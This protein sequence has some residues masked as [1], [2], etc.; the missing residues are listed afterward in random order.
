MG[1]H[2][3]FCMNMGWRSKG[4]S[5]LDE[6]IYGHR[7]LAEKRA[8]N[9]V[10]PS[11]DGAGPER[12]VVKE[13]ALLLRYDSPR[14]RKPRAIAAANLEFSAS[15]DGLPLYWL[16]PSE[17]GESVLFLQAF[18]AQTDPEDLRSSV[19]LAVG[20]HRNPDLVVPFLQRIIAGR[21]V[22]RI[23]ADAAALLGEQP[24]PKALEILKR[25]AAADASTEV[26]ENAVDGL[27]EMELPAAAGVLI[28]LAE[29]GRDEEVRNEAIHGLAE[30]ATKATIASLERL[31]YGDKNAEIRKEAI[32]AIAD[33]PQKGGLSFVIK[34]AKAHPDKEARIA[35]IEALGEFRDPAAQQALIDIIKKR[36]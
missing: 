25:T 5:T 36:V 27:I 21:E 7:T 9:A 10:L 6:W 28:E 15:L 31:A 30:K 20:L 29:R 34:A 17:D 3:N 32:Q 24:D 16:G 14:A 11:G 22:E 13:V 19:I 8:S 26:R 12:K 18:Y 35:A 23:R 33:L 2:S 4:A 1:E